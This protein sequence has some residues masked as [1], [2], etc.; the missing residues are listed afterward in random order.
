M[1][2]TLQYAPYFVTVLV[3]ILDLVHGHCSS[4]FCMCIS[5]QVIEVVLRLMLM[6]CDVGQPQTAGA[7]DRPACTFLQGGASLVL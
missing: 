1:L 4:C 7:I 2:F 6:S 3:V 5:I